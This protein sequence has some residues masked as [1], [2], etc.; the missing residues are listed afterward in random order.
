MWLPMLPMFALLLAEAIARIR[1]PVLGAA[2]AVLIAALTL[3]NSF[4]GR[5]IESLRKGDQFIAGAHRVAERLAKFPSSTLVAANNVGVIGYESRVRILDMMGLT[6][7]HIAHAPGKKVGIAG[8]E[9]HDGAY[10]LDQKPDVIILGMPRAVSKPNPAW[11]TGRQGYP[12]D[13]DVRR[14]PRFAE[15]YQLQ[16]L[17]LADGRWSPVYIR[18]GFDVD[19]SRE[20]P[21]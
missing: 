5:N 15:E 3:P 20:P 8:H 2:L 12:S 1:R 9:S 17:H 13:M 14:D 4:R 21:Q 6:D 19:E 18:R 11:D 7:E 10:V 16:Y